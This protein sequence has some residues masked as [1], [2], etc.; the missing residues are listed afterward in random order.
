MSTVA[1]SNKVKDILLSII[2]LPPGSLQDYVSLRIMYYVTYLN[3]G[4]IIMFAQH[5]V[6]YGIETITHM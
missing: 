1:D 6:V 3:H 5:N 4:I 2:Q